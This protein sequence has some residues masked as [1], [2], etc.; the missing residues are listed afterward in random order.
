VGQSDSRLYDSPRRFTGDT[1]YYDQL[2][3]TGTTTRV[4]FHFVLLTCWIGPHC[5]HKREEENQGDLCLMATPHALH[6]YVYDHD[7]GFYLAPCLPWPSLLT[8]STGLHLLYSTLNLPERDRTPRYT[9]PQT[10]RHVVAAV[11]CRI[12]SK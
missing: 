11:R 3:R 7:H 9:V 6:A 1:A 5:Y 8:H 2:M 10:R 12:Q 4:S